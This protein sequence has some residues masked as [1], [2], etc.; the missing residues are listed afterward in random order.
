[1]TCF[2]EQIDVSQPVFLGI[3][4]G[5]PLVLIVWHNINMRLINKRA[6]QRLTLALKT[7]Q[8]YKSL[9]SKRGISLEKD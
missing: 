1:M 6:K 3:V 5:I 8:A 7:Q 4:V 9:E 2:L